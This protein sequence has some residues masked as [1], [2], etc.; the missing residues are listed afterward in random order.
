MKKSIWGLCV[1]LLVLMVTGCGE[2]AKEFTKKCTATQNNVASGYNLESVYT[3]YGK[4]SVVN[5]VTSVET[6]VS[7]DASVLSY[8]ETTLKDTYDQ[9]NK[10]YGGYTNTVTNNDGKVV[11]ETTIDYNV[12][13][14][15][16]YVEDNSVM[17]NFVN[18]DNKLLVDGLVSIYEQT[19][20]ICE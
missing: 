15:S 4:G 19:G 2:E 18:E 1:C 9:Y 7:S 3:I 8:F 13:N 12:M 16:K 5:K 6:I 14:L 17:K 10:V 20:A 11:S